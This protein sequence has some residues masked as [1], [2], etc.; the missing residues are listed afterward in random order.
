L[1]RPA[2][3]SGAFAKELKMKN[4]MLSAAAILI[5][6]NAMADVKWVTGPFWQTA[7]VTDFKLEL[8][9]SNTEIAGEC[10]DF[11]RYV[12]D[13]NGV[14]QLTEADDFQVF[15]QMS[16]PSDMSHNQFYL[17]LKLSL[18][19]SL[20]LANLQISNPELKSLTDGKARSDIIPG[21]T[22]NPTLVNLSRESLTSPIRI[23]RE[24]KSLRAAGERLGV[25]ASELTFKDR[26]DGKYLVL[27]S[28]DIAC[29]L[30]AGRASLNLKGR[31]TVKISLENQLKVA[32]HFEEIEKITNNSFQQTTKPA[33]RAALLGFRLGEFFGRTQDK[34]QSEA[35]LLTL[36]PKLF[37]LETMNKSNIWTDAFGEKVLNVTG[38]S[39]PIDVNI[40]FIGKP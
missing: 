1:N 23:E 5:G 16:L 21:F 25:A 13:E 39:S 2:C 14:L 19:P 28:K 11:E 33:I 34:E 24:S 22:Q 31:A 15:N 38:T 9:H 3:P 7:Y 8:K 27:K 30:I 18:S 29:D 32:K 35:Q 17:E 12:M 4:L 40:Q 10:H 20:E 6:V 26:A 36:L 37:D